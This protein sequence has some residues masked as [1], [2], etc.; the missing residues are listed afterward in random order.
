MNHLSLRR[1]F[2]IFLSIF[3][4]SCQSQPQVRDSS[5][6]SAIS[7]FSQLESDFFKEL[8]AL[9][10]NYALAVG[11][12][13][14]DQQLTI[15]NEEYF[16][17]QK[18]FILKY[19]KQLESLDTKRLSPAEAMDRAI[20][21]NALAQMQW[22]YEKFKSWQWDPSNYNLGPVLALIVESHQRSDAQKKAALI[23]KFQQ[24]PQYYQAAEKNIENPTAEHLKLSIQQ[25]KGLMDYLQNNLTTILGSSQ[26][27]FLALE[28]A[29]NSVKKFIAFLQKKQSSKKLKSFRIG[30]LLYEEKFK[31]NLQ[32]R[33][34]PLQVYQE[35]IKAKAQAHQEMAHRAEQLWPKYFPKVKAP[36]DQL[37]MIRQVVDAVAQNHGSAEDFVPS[38]RK[39]IPEL[40]DFVVAKN[41]IT[42][43]P[44][45]KLKVRE[46]PEYE[47][48]VAGAGVDAPGPFDQDRETFYNVSPLTG[49]TK[50]Q[51]QS[52]LR[53]YNNYTLQIL[54]IHEAIPG[55]YVQLVYSLKSPSLTKKRFGN[56]PMVE[57]W[58]V[59]GERMMMEEGYGNNSPELWLM[60]YKWRLRVIC[61]TILDY[62][63]HT[64]NWS[65]DQAMN[66]LIKEAFQEKAEAEEKWKR[67]TLTQVQLVSYFSG[68]TEIYNFRES[69]KKQKGS[70]FSLKDFHEKFLSFGSAPIP[71]I[72]DAMGKVF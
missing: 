52:Y 29:K 34:T 62:S 8:W 71:L 22:E 68:Y 3:S 37:K 9:D 69:L 15:M 51:Q 67:A 23:A 13:E 19:Q 61:N 25:N 47:R 50:E 49:M 39:Q 46:T 43:D 21:L 63:I 26:E 66:L 53:E 65:H 54:N 12:Q 31:Y 44:S 32:I 48:G 70:A 57:G 30:S 24:F 59:Y 7:A 1:A 27:A 36:A 55:H 33:L 45:K 72:E 20:L 56:G 58:A 60:Y 35:A 2:A 6:T 18:F 28:T 10:P 11:R 41:L 42:L 4:I 40:W 38:I 17:N 16:K 5:K 14:Q 64:Q